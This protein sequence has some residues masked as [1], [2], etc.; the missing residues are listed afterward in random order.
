MADPWDSH[1]GQTHHDPRDEE[2]AR[3]KAENERLCDALIEACC[4]LEDARNGAH[5][6][7][8]DLDQ[9]LR[10]ASGAVPDDRKVT[11]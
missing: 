8:L 4:A 9:A 1:D 2:I 10:S 3:L 5:N 11:S 7:R 6:A